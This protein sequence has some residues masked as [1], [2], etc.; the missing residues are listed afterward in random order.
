MGQERRMQE[1]L[2]T[3]SSDEKYAGCVFWGP[4]IYFVI[5][6]GSLWAIPDDAGC[7]PRGGW[8]PDIIAGPTSEESEC[9]QKM[10]DELGFD[11]EFFN[12]IIEDYGEIDDDYVQEY[13]EDNDDEDAAKLYRKMKR[14]VNSGTPLR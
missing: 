13:F 12:E 4:G 2:D 8:F 9:L 3:I 11:E 10:M 5:E 7:S 6:N 1:L 14:K